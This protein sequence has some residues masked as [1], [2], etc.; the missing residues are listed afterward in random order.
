MSGLKRAA[1]AVAGNPIVDDLGATFVWDG[2]GDP[3]VV[4]GSWSDWD[5]ARALHMHAVNGNWEARLEVSADAYAEYRFYRGGHPLRDPRNHARVDNGVDGRNHQFWMPRAT[6]RAIEHAYRRDVPRGTVTRGRIDLGWLAAPPQRRRAAFYLPSDPDGD[7]DEA[8][9]RA[10]PLL[11]VLDGI[12]YLRRGKLARI[13]DALIADR[14]MAPVAAVFLDNSGETRVAEY[15]ANDLTLAALADVAVPAAMEQLGIAA[16]QVPG[17]R[18]RA[19]ILG[20]SLGGLMALHAGVRRPDVFGSVIAQ[21]TSAML[22]DIP[23]DGST[24]PA[25]RLTTLALLEATEPPPI[26]LWLDVG[27]LEGL[28]P[29]NDRLAAMLTERGLDLRY[30]RYPGGHDHTSWAESL[31]DALPA[32]FPPVESLE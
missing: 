14:R 23:M 25:I 20:S 31:V 5:P 9:R 28:A 30:R 19:T 15:A 4:A 10:L 7:G 29:S 18:G 2:A 11:L 27:D 12:D 8:I 16:Q 32:M 3:P 1:A 13:L 6:R 24:L 22:E 21:S 17:G 26:R